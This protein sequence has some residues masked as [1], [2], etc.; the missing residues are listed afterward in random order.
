[1][2]FSVANMITFGRILVIPIMVVLMGLIDSNNSLEYN[3]LLSL[4]AAVI[5]ILAAISDLVDGY[6]ARKQKTVSLLGKFIDPMADK[7]IHMAAMV[8]LIPLGRLPAW[9]AVVLLFREIFISGIRAVAAGEGLV[10]DAATWGKRK[11][12]WLNMGF[13]GLILY[14]PWFEGRP[15]EINIYLVG[16][17]CL[18]IGFLYSVAS[19]VS[20]SIVFFKKVKQ[21]ANKNSQS[22]GS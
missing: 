13:I 19:A 8:M 4:W 18:G 15:Y 16:M 6:L 7:L 5:F 14:Y 12:A 20:Y 22:G 21:P 1:M 9:V 10:I 3:K 17:I 11:T 2:I